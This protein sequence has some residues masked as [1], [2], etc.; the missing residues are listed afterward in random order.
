MR[1]GAPYASAATMRIEA[2]LVVIGIAATGRVSAA[3]E[4]V[5]PSQDNARCALDVVEA[6]GGQG[7]W[8]AV[9]SYGPAWRPNEDVVGPE[10]VPFVTGGNWVLRNGAQY[11]A[12]RW[13]WGE[14]VF[15]S[16][17]WTLHSTEGWV[18]LPDQRC[19]KRSEAASKDD[20]PMPLP[21]LLSPIKIRTIKHPLG[22]QYA[23]PYGR[24]WGRV[25]PTGASIAAPRW[26]APMPTAPTTLVNPAVLRAP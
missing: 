1:D 5:P 26:I 7:T 22:T 14:I 19:V 13:S 20:D 15:T 16:G 3:Q 6:L 17:R 8:L 9:Q 18:W 12:S 21:P 4:C 11:F 23:Y 25:F 24:E 2:W 10:F